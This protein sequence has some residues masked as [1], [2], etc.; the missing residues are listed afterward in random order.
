MF[1]NKN[2]INQVGGNYSDFYGIYSTY[3]IISGFQL[4]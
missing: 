3:K 1:N 4:N 2:I